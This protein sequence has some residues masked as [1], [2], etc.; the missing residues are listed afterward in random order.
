MASSLK[1]FRKYW[2]DWVGF[3]SFRRTPIGRSSFIYICRSHL[4]DLPPLGFPAWPDIW[5]TGRAFL[6]CT[7]WESKPAANNWMHTAK[8]QKRF[9]W[10]S[11]ISPSGAVSFALSARLPCKEIYMRPFKIK[12]EVKVPDSVVLSLNNNLTDKHLSPCSLH[13]PRTPMSALRKGQHHT[14]WWRGPPWKACGIGECPPSRATSCS[15]MS[16][17]AGPCW[18][19]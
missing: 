4:L 12:N 18:R 5:A 14:F 15:P 2:L 8:S 6:L 17:Q 3:I 9:F 13:E 16:L 7:Q 11:V 10:K 1:E 19:S